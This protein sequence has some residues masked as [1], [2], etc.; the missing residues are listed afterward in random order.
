MAEISST[1]TVSIQSLLYPTTTDTQTTAPVTQTDPSVTTTP[2]TLD[3]SVLPSSVRGYSAATLGLTPPRPGGAAEADLLAIRQLLDDMNSETK[4]NE[5]MASAQRKATAM[6]SALALLS[7]MVTSMSEAISLTVEKPKAF[8]AADQANQDYQAKKSVADGVDTKL[9]PYATEYKDL[10]NVIEQA[11]KSIEGLD[12]QLKVVDDGIKLTDKSIKNAEGELKDINDEI[13]NKNKELTNLNTQYTL[14]KDAGKKKIL[15]DK[16]KDAEGELAR[17]GNNKTQKETD[18]SNLRTTLQGYQKQWGELVGKRDAEVDKIKKAQERLD[19]I[20]PTKIQLEGELAAARKEE[21]E[22]ESTYNTLQTYA[23]GIQRRIDQAEA[24][25]AATLNGFT[26]LANQLAAV[27]GTPDGGV[28]TELLAFKKENAEAL[29]ELWKIMSDSREKLG[30]DLQTNDAINSRLS[31]LDEVRRAKVGLAFSSIF[32]SLQDALNTMATL[33][34][35][36][37]TSGGSNFSERQPQR[38]RFSIGGSA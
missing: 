37:S 20:T 35:P 24:D 38:M 9:Q 19:V 21:K 10:N 15:A 18:I 33:M 22:A 23:N 28:E 2:V 36:A 30:A 16:I 7:G 4:D 5:I 12:S 8:A 13:S 6:G 1:P 32:T 31:D 29:K 3:T 11:N 17:L 27:P 25:F 26:L 34:D 14:E